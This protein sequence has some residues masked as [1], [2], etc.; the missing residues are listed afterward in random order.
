M[1]KLL[2]IISVVCVALMVGCGPSAEE[3]QKI[4]QA[5]L[6]SIAQS[7]QQAMQDS[8]NQA[9][10]QARQD[11]VAMAQAATDSINKWKADSL[12]AVEAKLKGMSKPK[13]KPKPKEP[14]K[15]EEVK[16]GQGRG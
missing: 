12:A 15:P 1:K 16:P 10:E 14:T 3:Q 8:I 11:S 6:D 7:E 4:E 5:R 9:M 2:T 13:P